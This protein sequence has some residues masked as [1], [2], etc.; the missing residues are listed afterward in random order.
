MR[1]HLVDGAVDVVITSPPYN[2]G[3]KYSAYKDVLPREEYLKWLGQ[4]AQEV[5]RV[6]A[7][8]GSFFL[9][10]G[11]KPSDAW[12]P[13]DVAMVMRQ[14]FELQ[15]TIHWI[16]SITIDQKDV[17]NYGILSRDLS[18]G[19]FKPIQSKRYL[20]DCHEYVFHFTK[21]GDVGLDRLAIGTPYQD[22]SNV[23]RWQGAAAD[24]RCR[25]NN[26]FVP[27]KTIQ[28]R[29]HERPH[30]ATFPVELARKAIALHGIRPGL[31]VC[32]PFLG[33]GH[34][35]VAAIEAG[36]DFMGF[37]IDPEYFGVACAL[38]RENTA[39]DFID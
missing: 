4:W 19:H 31:V 12:L 18:V 2:I 39:S 7:D 16:K 37:E 17:G 29:K 30:P 26:W 24:L 13:L 6:L 15:N 8:T 36:V 10:V 23:T 25:G 20:N 1:D 28:S 33:I 3:I 22:K 35:G 32:D 21:S 27:Y 38:L 9:N 34:A 5:R 11:C 14:H